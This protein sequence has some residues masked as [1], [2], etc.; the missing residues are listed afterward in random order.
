MEVEKP[1]TK[2][3]KK[4]YKKRYY[5]FSKFDRGIKLD[6]ES[7]YSVTP[8]TIAKH[9]AQRVC[10]VFGDE[11]SNV[12]D[13]CCGCGGNLI[14]FARKCGF[15]VGVDLDPI[16]VEYAQHNSGIYNVD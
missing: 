4:F 12:M 13:G 14:Q 6:E 15:A 16:K 2:D 8:E 5:L 10:D 7:W 1:K 3:I 9:T 11:C